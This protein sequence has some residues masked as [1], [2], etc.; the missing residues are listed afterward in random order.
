MVHGKTTTIKSIVGLSNIDNG[1]I[2]VDGISSK[3][4]ILNVKKIISYIPDN[5]DLYNNLTGLE[6]LKFVSNIYNINANDDILKYSKM[7]EMENDLNNLISSY[8]H[9]MK[10]KLAIICALIHKPKLLILDE[11]FVGLDPKAQ[12]TLKDIMKDICKQGSS[13]FF[14][15]HILEVVEKLCDRVAIINKGEIVKIR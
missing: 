10:Q 3:T 4:D 11:P 9:G 5:P 15:S 13:V 6:Y 14:S 1:D 8:S 7:F 12:A 2:L